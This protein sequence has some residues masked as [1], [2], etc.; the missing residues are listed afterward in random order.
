MPLLIIIGIIVAIAIYDDQNKRKQA[1]NKKKIIGYD[2][3]TGVPLYEGEKVTGYDTQTGRAII[4]GREE[5]K[6]VINA[7][8]KTPN[9]LSMAKDLLR[10]FFIVFPIYF[11]IYYHKILEIPNRK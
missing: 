4:S 2:T 1:I 7:K 10:K 3:R 8:E 11:I 9:M 5:L 6:R